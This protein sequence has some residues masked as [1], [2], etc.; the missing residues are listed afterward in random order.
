VLLSP[1]CAARSRRFE[2][3]HHPSWS[4]CASIA[5]LARPRL[6]CDSGRAG[7]GGGFMRKPLP[8][9]VEG[10]DLIHAH[11]RPR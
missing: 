6:L 10:P 11:P 7:D 5:G 1:R 8:Q 9:V 3:A 2:G 4:P